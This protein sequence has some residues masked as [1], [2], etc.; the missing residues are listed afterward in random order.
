MRVLV[1][2]GKGFNDRALVQSVLGAFE[3]EHGPITTLIHGGS[4]SVDFLTKEWATLREIPVEE[5]PPIPSRL[6]RSSGP[7]RNKSLLEKAK[8]NALVVFPGGKGTRDMMLKA[9][10]AGVHR[11]IADWGP[12]GPRKGRGNEDASRRAHDR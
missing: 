11:F 9:F 4:T 3:Q 12:R 2:G 7:I 1:C 10:E 5:Y 6:G 8:P